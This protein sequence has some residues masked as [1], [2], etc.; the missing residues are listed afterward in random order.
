[1]FGT[2]TDEDQKLR[3]VGIA[4]FIWLHHPVDIALDDADEKREQRGG[5][6][7]E[8]DSPCA[9]PRRTRTRSSARW[10]AQFIWLHHPVE[11]ALDDA[12]EK[13]EQ[14]G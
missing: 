8:I 14:R 7:I 10:G 4:P 13:R 1:M 9:R 5:S 3:A 2:K 6:R 12:D 11:I